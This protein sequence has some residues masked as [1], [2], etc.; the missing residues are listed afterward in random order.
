MPGD[1]ILPDFFF[2]LYL[3][4][5]FLSNLGKIN[6]NYQ[7]KFRFQ[8]RDENM[9]NSLI[10]QKLKVVLITFFCS[11][12]MSDVSTQAENSP[13][14]PPSTEIT[15]PNNQRPQTTDP[16]NQKPKGKTPQQ[17]GKEYPKLIQK[18][19]DVVTAMQPDMQIK[20]PLGVNSPILMNIKEGGNQPNISKYEIIGFVDKNK[21]PKPIS[22]NDLRE[23]LE[24][25]LKQINNTRENLQ[26]LNKSTDKELVAEARNNAPQKKVAVVDI[27]AIDKNTDEVFL[28][29]NVV[30]ITILRD[31]I[32]AALNKQIKPNNRNVS[33]LKVNPNLQQNQLPPNNTI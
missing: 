21:K 24:Q 9:K 22:T 25:H 19:K 28:I 2:Y 8:F 12:C 3:V 15:V 6:K 5:Y 29:P 10:L 11:A 7:S 16:T 1:F 27:I 20:F 14:P 33:Q 18:A 32:N 30:F 17:L 23:M 13:T 26:S 31:A 4:G